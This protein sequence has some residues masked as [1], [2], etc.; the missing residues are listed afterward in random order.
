MS[1]LLGCL[2]NSGEGST[3][4]LE[5]SEMRP[6]MLDLDLE[7]KAPYRYQASSYAFVGVMQFQ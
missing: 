4:L 5:L 7:C 2:V 3:E 6:G 1:P